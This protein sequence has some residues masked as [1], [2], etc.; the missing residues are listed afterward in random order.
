MVKYKDKE[1]ETR[2]LVEI[3]RTMRRRKRSERQREN[4]EREGYNNMKPNEK[5]NE[6]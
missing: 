2:T 1:G 5:R 4:T 3:W 6:T